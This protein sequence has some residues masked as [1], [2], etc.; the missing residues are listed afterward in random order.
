VR[1]EAGGVLE[2]DVMIKAPEVKIQPGEE[3]EIVAKGQWMGV[4][5]E[6]MD[7]DQKDEEL[8]LKEGGGIQRGGFTSN[9]LMVKA[10]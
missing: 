8:S 5:V 4:W 10:S 3:Y 1:I 9:V 7:E 2:R 6:I